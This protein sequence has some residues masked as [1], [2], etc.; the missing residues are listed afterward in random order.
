MGNPLKDVRFAL[1]QV[2][3]RPGF[4]AVVVLTLALGIGANTAIFS[5]VE[6]VLLRG[7][8]YPEPEELV[9]VWPDMVTNARS[10]EWLAESTPSIA[11]ISGLSVADFALTGDEGR[12]AER[13]FGARVFPGHFEV[14]RVRPLLGRTFRPEESDP[15]RSAVVVLDHSLWRTRYGGDPGIVGRTIRIDYAP[16]T[17]VGVMPP[18][19]RPLETRFRLWVPQEVDPGT[20]VETDGTWWITTRIGRLAPGATVE[21]AGRE[22]Q[23]AAARLAGRIPTEID[24]RRAALATV[25]PLRDA[26]VGSLDRTLWILLGAVGLVLLVACANVA[27]LLLSRTP[28]KGREVAVRTA[29]GASRGR[30]VA[31]L[32]VESLVLGL[33]GGAVGVALAWGSLDVLRAV[34]PPDLPRIREV[35]VDGGVL[36]FAAGVSLITALLF[37]LVPALRATALDARGALGGGRGAVGLAARNRLGAGL[38]AAEVAIA[39]VLVIGAGLMARTVRNLMEVDPGFR[40]EGVLTMQVSMPPVAD[41]DA[42]AGPDLVLYRRLWD[43][44]GG[45]PGVEAVGGIHILPLGGGNNR[46]PFWA[47]GNE[48]AA[49]EL[50]PAANIRVATP[51]YLEVM[52]IPLEEG[53]W[54]TVADRLETTPVMVLNRS[55]ARRLWPDGSA[56]GRRVRL[57]A[58]DGFEWEV[59]GIVSDVTQ[60]SLTRDPSGEIYLP[61]EQWTWPSMFVTIRATGRPATLAPRVV[62]AIGEVDPDITVSRVSTMDRVVGA[63]IAPDRFLAGLMGAFGLLAL[64]LGAVGVYGVVSCAVSGRMSE[65]AVRMALGSTGADILETTVARGLGPVAIGVVLGIVGAWGATRLLS[66]LLFEVSPADPLT[67]AVVALVLAA[68]AGVAWWLPAR[69]AVRVDPMVVLREE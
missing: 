8:P 3:R 5:L 53:R 49:A 57:L 20:T 42:G 15:G 43:D 1:R 55:L 9:A 29:L 25:V 36:A 4:A 44:L 2:A 10:A 39:V 50:A 60:M 21:S 68:V 64:V 22:L 19:Y 41:A 17:V 45:L 54:F 14:M 46:Y 69:R 23:A 58:E 12:P 37:G 7:L 35:R 33:L 26:L 18:D 31:Q 24:S 13:V 27:N 47:E 34:A 32:L 62:R 63:S 61:H 28:S 56:V 66:T 59:V 48:P 51:G 40:T 52:D 6:G 65:F 30:V 11:G 67:Y 16:Y 38:V